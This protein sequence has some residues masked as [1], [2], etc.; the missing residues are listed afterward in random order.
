MKLVNQQCGITEARSVITYAPTGTPTD[1]TTPSPTRTHTFSP[2]P[3]PTGTPTDAS[4]KS[5]SSNPTPSSTGTPTDASTDSPTPR[6]TSP[7]Q[8]LNDDKGLEVDCGDCKSR[9]DAAPRASND[10]VNE[11]YQSIALNNFNDA[12]NI[13]NLPFI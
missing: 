4:Y 10:N 11:Y 5:T 2:T 12:S 1:S 13:I 8:N 7:T 6:P 9:F 3:S